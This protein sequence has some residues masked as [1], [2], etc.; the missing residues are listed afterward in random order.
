MAPDATT[1]VDTKPTDSLE[2]TTEAT[3]TALEVE[4]SSNEVVIVNEEGEKKKEEIE[5]FDVGDE[6]RQLLELS[7][8]VSGKISSKEWDEIAMQSKSEKYIVQ[9]GD[10]LWKIS[11]KLFGSGFYY[12]KIWSLNPTI[13]NPHQIE[14]GMELAFD[15]GTADTLPQVSVNGL[16]GK[17]ETSAP[18]NGLQDLSQFGELGDGAAWSDERK[19]LIDQGVY[20]QYASESTYDDLKTRGDKSLVK[21]YNSYQPPVTDITIKEPGVEYDPSGF[22]K[23]S[24]VKFDFSE[25]YYLNT[26]ITSNILADVGK[27]SAIPNERTFIH[28]A[29]HI[30]VKFDRGTKIR[31]G[32]M[33]SSYSAHGKSSHPISDRSGYRYTI[34]AQLKTIRPIN[35][36]WECEVDD[37]SG[38]V[39]RG[40]RVTLYMS[41]INKVVKYFN[42]RHIEAA[43]MDS[44]R[45]Q[46]IFSAGDVVYLDRGRADGVELGTVFETYDFYDR[47]TGKKISA[48]PAYKTGEVTVITVTDNFSTALITN[49]SHAM[50]MGTI[51]ITKT[52]EQVAREQRMKN[53]LVNKDGKLV[54]SG[55]LDELDVELNLDDI[56]EDLLDK[57]DKVKLSED[58]L[59]ELDRQER[60]KSIIKDHESDLQELER[61]EKELENI[62]TKSKEYKVDEDKLLEQENLDTVEKSAQEAPADAFMSLDDIESESG[63]QYLDQD[64]NSKDNPYGLTE[65]DLEEIDE[66]LKSD[67]S[68]AK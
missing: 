61:L 4:K 20:F 47:G 45:D 48:L 32:D 49:S 18:A 15:T 1:V 29:D 51:A 37:I 39:T 28:K 41:K 44:P 7:K 66:L 24:K 13:T 68:L 6:E 63:V 34:T 3:A 5:I 21:E 30:F 27:I 14:P 2:S 43:F 56:S 33:Y 25:G 54:E 31:P 60:E 9:K 59:E 58:E 65:F 42:K 36:L 19:K 8:F 26:F 64:L 11:E 52:A 67:P 16:D 55:V 35:D 23:F 12:S 17:E 62:E 40:D 10:W 46:T 22:D 53:K 38:V 50:K 57:A